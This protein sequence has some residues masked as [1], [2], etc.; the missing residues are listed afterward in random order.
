MFRAFATLGY[1][2]RRNTAREISV[3]VTKPGWSSA[4]GLR[5][6]GHKFGQSVR[7]RD[8]GTNFGPMVAEGL[9][10]PSGT[11]AQNKFRYAYFNQ[12]HRLAVELN[13][14]VTV[15][16][17]LDHQISGVSA[18]GTRRF[19]HPYQPTRYCECLNSARRLGGRGQTNA[20]ALHDP[21]ATKPNPSNGPPEGDIF[22]KIEG[23]A[24][25]QKKGILSAEVRS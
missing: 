19:A 3:A 18:A 1:P 2:S 25:L 9:G 8:T 13:G 5:H 15:Y 14:R 6:L 7:T 23:L 11:G 17:T 24:D 12:T 21:P 10:F 16:D 22:A 20:P 4:A